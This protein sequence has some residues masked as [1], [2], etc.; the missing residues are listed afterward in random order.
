MWT[1]SIEEL[2]TAVTLD[3]GFAAAHAYLSMAHLWQGYIDAT[4]RARNLPLARDAALKALELDP[5]LPEAHLAMACYLYRGEA[6]IERAASEFERAIRGLPN[7][8]NAYKFFGALRRWQGRWEEA[9]ALY[10]RAAE[11]DPQGV[12]VWHQISI[13][14]ALGRKDEALKAAAAGRLAQPDEATLVTMPGDIALTFS[15]DIDTAL[16]V[17]GDAAKQFPDSPDVA[18]RRGWLALMTGDASAALRYV[19]GQS[20]VDAS[21]ASVSFLRSLIYRDLGRQKESDAVLRGYLQTVG[22]EIQKMAPVAPSSDELAWIAVH[23]ALLGDR[24]TAQDAA[25]H[26]IAA[27]PPSGDAATRTTTFHDV[28][29]A[30]AWAGDPRGAVANL[31]SVLDAPGEYKPASIWCDPSFAPLRNDAGFRQMLAER[32][33]D[34]RIDPHRRETWPRH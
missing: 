4:T 18:Q 1:E 24:R 29:I 26:A 21:D 34:L 11:L 20:S 17:F 25:R 9:R 7:D 5:T 27:L 8:S 31:K 32:G 16:R 13:L 19:E 10:A 30:L 14:V 6:D 28:A 2:T 3:P 33:A 22:A 23:H 15:C 12:A